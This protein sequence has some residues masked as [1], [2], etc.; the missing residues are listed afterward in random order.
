MKRLLQNLPLKMKIGLIVLLPLCGYLVTT[1]NNLFVTYGQYRSAETVASLVNFDGQISQLVHE[2]QKERG[3]SAGFLASK[4]Q[5][6][7]DTLTD[8]RT[9]TDKKTAAY[10]NILAGVENELTGAALVENIRQ[11]DTLLNGLSAMRQKVSGQQVET[12]DAIGYYTALITSLLDLTSAISH[13]SDDPNITVQMFAYVNFLQ[14]KE[15]SGIERA[16]LS[17]V[18]SKGAFTTATYN[19]FLQLLAGQ[20]NYLAMFRAQALPEA[21][22]LYDATVKGS[23]VDEV[24]RM[25]QTALNVGLDSSKSFDVDPEVWFKTITEKIN[26][27]KSVDDDLAKS[28]IN[29]ASLRADAMKSR[30]IFVMVVFAVILAA[31]LTL[32]ATTALSLIAG[33]NKANRIA[34]DLA[35]GD[36]DLTKRMNFKAKDEI[37][38]LGRSIDTLLTTLAGMIGQI[39]ESGETLNH[40]GQ[41]LTALAEQMSG[42]TANI[43][44]RANGA[45]ASSNEMNINM[46]SVAAA[47]EEAAINISTVATSTGEVASAGKDIADSTKNA[48]IMTSEAVTH[49]KSSYEMISTLGDA[50]KEIGRVT[51]TITEISSQ[52]NLLA[53]N[54]T[55]EAAR[56]GEAGKGFSV[57]ANEIKELA[58]QTAGATV[59]INAKIKSIQDSTGN[60]IDEIQ[61]I[62]T[63]IKN[64][65]TIVDGIAS[66]VDNQTTATNEI[67]QNINKAS[68]GLQEVAGNV[69]N[70][71]AVSAEVAK[72]IADV[73]FSSQELTSS[74]NLVKQSAIDLNNLTA[75]MHSATD[76]FKI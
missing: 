72:D 5:K 28:I 9:A 18:F 12:K 52:T 32:M 63:V 50:A 8:Q 48:L 51:E 42:A 60:T 4:G 38:R 35:E 55:I 14:S 58:K 31:S 6:F 43:Q 76:R 56:A 2:L 11:T 68:I 75:I 27:L 70:I 41:E 67:A 61:K 30:L 47:V 54:A 3:S 15:R 24:E 16:I 23:A 69:S 19:R 53:L 25:R 26:L 21:R 22:E 57:V 20:E 40:S 65:D 45:A 59:E 46:N 34:L 64:V 71:S 29:S 39:K 13:L 74:S 37:G 7:V 49:S 17:A 73:S 10:K 66:A 33:I 36:G 44:T 62:L 1:G